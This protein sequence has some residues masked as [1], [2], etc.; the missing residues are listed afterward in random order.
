MACFELKSIE[1]RPSLVPSLFFVRRAGVVNSLVNGLFRFCSKRN[2][3]GAP[4]RYF[5]KVT[6]RTAQMAIKEDMAVEELCKRLS[7][8][9]PEN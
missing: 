8:T 2:V 6:S 1:L 5:I 7:R 4:I 3:G 9:E